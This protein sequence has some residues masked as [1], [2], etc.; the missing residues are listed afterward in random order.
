M[1]DLKL[2]YDNLYFVKVNDIKYSAYRDNFKLQKRSLKTFYIFNGKYLLFTL[3]KTGV[4]YRI[5]YR[6]Y[7]IK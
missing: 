2:K 7:V 4:V 5:F 3:I 1:Q 6:I